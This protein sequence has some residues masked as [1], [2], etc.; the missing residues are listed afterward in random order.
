MPDY[1][2]IDLD[3]PDHESITVQG[4]EPGPQGCAYTLEILPGPHGLDPVC[5]NADIVLTLEG[6]ERRTATFMT[7]ENIRGFIHAKNPDAPHDA[8][9]WATNLVVVKSLDP[10][11]I[12]QTVQ[13][14]MKRG[15]IQLVFGAPPAL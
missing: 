6:G 2:H 8:Y 9:V 11:H 13:A 4:R 12:A 3:G 1:E 14:M 7:I 10:G 5:G 15:E